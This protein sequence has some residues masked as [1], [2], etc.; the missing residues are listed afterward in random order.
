MVSLTFRV[1]L[2]TSAK[3]VQTYPQ[4]Y[5]QVVTQVSVNPFKI[6]IKIICLSMH[7]QAHL[8]LTSI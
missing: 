7:T 2:P 5:K 3:H 1:V 4:R 8:P 6:T